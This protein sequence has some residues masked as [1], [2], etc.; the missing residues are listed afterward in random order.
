MRF[1]VRHHTRYR[2][3]AP[4]G[5]ARH[6]VRLTPRPGQ[7]DL[8]SHAV[9]V[10][11]EPAA[12]QTLD[13]SHGNRLLQLEFSGQ[14][15]ELSVDSEF[16]LHTR[17]P[18]SLEGA[19][20]ALPWRQPDPALAAYLA[21]G[22][23]DP[24]V[25]EFAE[26]L[27]AETGREPVAFLDLLTHTL[28][29]DFDRHIRDAGHAHPAAE[30]LALRR[31]A[32][33][34]LAVLFMDAT[35]HLGIPSRFVSGYQARREAVDGRRHLHAWPEVHLPTFGF[36]GWDPTHGLRV[37]EGHVAL[38]A[39]PTQLETMPVEGAFFVDGGPVNST[40]DFS[41]QIDAA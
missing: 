21:A 19:L 16:E 26:A 29:S 12:R 31:G 6:V 28:Y 13:D 24:S 41:L 32:C 7:G 22:A 27:A 11:P 20:P 5:L 8:L 30:T 35:R 9:H 40:L 17:P 15:Q 38:C 18:A 33:R 39:A 14:C 37:G 34:D 2:Y 10:T 4:V 3:D 25:A 1:V 23:V 36:R